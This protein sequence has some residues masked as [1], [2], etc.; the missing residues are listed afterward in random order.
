MQ[1]DIVIRGMEYEHTLGVPGLHRGV[2][3]GYAPMRIQETFDAMVPGRALEVCEFSLANYLTLR[4]T[5]HDWL[6]A[7]PVFPYRAFRHS[8]AVTR[9]DSVL[10]NL[11]E[12]RGRRVG[13]EA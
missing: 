3:L 8:L 1:P 2:T 4:A 12:L 6:T 9:K 11:I 13:G 10:T 5:G 7:I